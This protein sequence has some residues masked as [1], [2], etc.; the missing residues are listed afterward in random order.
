MTELL[1]ASAGEVSALGGFKP[2]QVNY[3]T[4]E[5]GVVKAPGPLIPVM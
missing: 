3:S 4:L 2:A 1:R 5:P